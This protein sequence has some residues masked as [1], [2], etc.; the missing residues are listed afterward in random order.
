MEYELDI[1]CNSQFV[2]WD[3][4][5][6]QLQMFIQTQQ[7]SQ[8]IWT[9]TLLKL[10]ATKERMKTRQR[11]EAIQQSCDVLYGEPIPV[12]RKHNELY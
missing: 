2:R 8:V 10:V 1:H 12:L 7:P 6:S 5:I 4:T 11:P 3:F 9:P